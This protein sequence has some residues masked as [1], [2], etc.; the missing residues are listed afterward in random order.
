MLGKAKAGVVAGVVVLGML[1]SSAAVAA[2]GRGTES[3]TPKAGVAKV[4]AYGATSAS[5]SATAKLASCVRSV[6]KVKNAKYRGLKC[7]TA[8]SKVIGSAQGRG[9]GKLVLT[10]SEGVEAT[11]ESSMQVTPVSML[12]AA[13]GFSVTKSYSV[14]K[15]TRYEVPRGRMGYV[16]AYPCYKLYSYELWTNGKFGL[17]VKR[18]G[19][20][21]AGKPTGV[22]FK[23]W[24]EKV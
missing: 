2:S 17:G 15:Q 8:R 12:S 9:P 4:E 16:Q 6:C 5:Q 22:Y 23:Q 21:I 1:S 10:I 19:N 3:I 7:A 13:V 14:E 24:T 11:H 18:I 20:G